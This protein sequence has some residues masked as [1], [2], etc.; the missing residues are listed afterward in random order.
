MIDCPY[1]RAQADVSESRHPRHGVACPACGGTFFVAGKSALPYGGDISA[2]PA[3]KKVACPVCGQHYDL[4]GASLSRNGVIMCEICYTAFALPQTIYGEA[5]EQEVRETAV[6][7]TAEMPRTPP[8]DLSAVADET[9][10]LIREAPQP[11][12]EPVLEPVSQ[13]GSPA[14]APIINRE[15][16]DAKLAEAK[17]AA[18]KLGRAAAGKADEL[19]NRL[20]LD[21]INAKLGGKVNVKSKKFK[22]ILA[23]AL[24]LLLIVIGFLCFGG[25]SPKSVARKFQKALIKGDLKTAEK[26]FY[27]GF[28]R[29]YELAREN[30]FYANY[31]GE[32]RW[33][34][35]RG[36]KKFVDG[37]F[38]KSL[39]EQEFD[40]VEIKDLEESF[41]WDKIARVRSR[42]YV[43]ELGHNKEKGKWIIGSFK[44][45]D[46]ET[47]R[48]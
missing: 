29:A 27:H 20:P 23:S 48:W 3:V 14:A 13:P 47:P 4:T 5:Q 42:N 39:K 18:G 37:F 43:L 9:Q 11:I 22:I 31:K 44:Y 19:Y 24:A 17:E 32:D 38:I 10:E 7:E 46:K 40:D 26:F 21:R 2:S 6:S 36:D 16:V 1:C 33:E 45:R 12:P 30:C 35:Y 15:A 34:K 28:D 25:N 8:M 41:D